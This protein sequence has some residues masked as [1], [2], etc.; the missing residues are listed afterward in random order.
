MAAPKEPIRPGIGP[1]GVGESTRTS[2]AVSEQAMWEQMCHLQSDTRSMLRQSI[3]LTTINKQMLSEQQQ[4]KALTEK[5]TER[6]VQLGESVRESVE[7][8]STFM[9]KVEAAMEQ[10]ADAISTLKE[11]VAA[12][13][14]NVDELVDEI[15]RSADDNEINIDDLNDSIMQIKESALTLAY[16]LY[17][18]KKVAESLAKAKKVVDAERPGRERERRRTR[19]AKKADREVAAIQVSESKR[20]A[21]MRRRAG[22]ADAG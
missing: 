13:D 14:D 12:S 18:D 16:A 22:G 2:N 17:D 1:M 9:S 3:E 8:M 19:I 6:T 15:R 20:A 11:A 5:L 4:L 7:K 21:R 10:V